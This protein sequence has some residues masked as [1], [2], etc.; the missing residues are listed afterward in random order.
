MASF[1]PFGVLVPRWNR[2]SFT[3]RDISAVSGPTTRS[4]RRER[5]TG[6]SAAR[7]LLISLRRYPATGWCSSADRRR[8][9]RQAQDR[10]LTQCI[11]VSAINIKI[12]GSTATRLR[13][14]PSRTNVWIKYAMVNSAF[15]K[16]FERKRTENVVKVWATVCV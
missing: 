3:D 9:R 6:S 2:L 14:S 1:S 7:D 4:I 11:R 13:S 8:R 5:R 10:S 16:E 12:R 15:L